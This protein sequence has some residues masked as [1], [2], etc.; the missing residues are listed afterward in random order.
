MNVASNT[1]AIINIFGERLKT[2]TMG[3]TFDKK[4]ADLARDTYNAE[5]PKAKLTA[6]FG[7]K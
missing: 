2:A 1:L 6:D 5:N 3:N 7:I 4:V